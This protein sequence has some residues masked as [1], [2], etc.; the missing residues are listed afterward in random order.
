MTYQPD[1]GYLMY[2]YIYIFVSMFLKSFFFSHKVQSNG[3][4]NF[5]QIYVTH[6]LTGTSTPSQIIWSRLNNQPSHLQMKG[7]LPLYG[8]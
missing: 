4:E 2:M 8:L 6:T 1:K 7:I 5:T 3:K